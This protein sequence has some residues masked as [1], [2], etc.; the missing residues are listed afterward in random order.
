MSF[1]LRSGTKKTSVVFAN[2]KGNPD[3]PITIIDTKGIVDPNLSDTERIGRNEE[4][5]RD[6]L[7][8][9]NE[10][11]G[12]HLFV[13]CWNGSNPRLTASLVEMLSILQNM[14]GHRMEGETSI[15]DVQEFWRRCVISY[16][17]VSWDESSI[18][19]RERQMRGCKVQD[20][21]DAISTYFGIDSSGIE[22]VYIDALYDAKDDVQ[23]S[24]FNEETEKI[25]DYLLDRDPMM[26]ATLQNCNRNSSRVLDSRH[27][28]ISL[29]RNYE[30]VPIEQAVEEQID[31]RGI[32]L[33]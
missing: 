31:E 2:F 15:V 6:I 21:R 8:K 33:P 12:I 17:R 20:M 19:I 4:I 29:N 5:Q 26:I 18:R 28:S 1:G 14:F 3:R 32:K 25:Y 24:K 7:R 23:L 9:L 13:I 30:T 27:S 16:S 10:I 22:C 11:D